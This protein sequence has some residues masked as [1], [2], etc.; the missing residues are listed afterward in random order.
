MPVTISWDDH[1]IHI[2]KTY[3]SLVG[4]TLYQLDTE[5]FRLDLRA[6][7]ADVYGIVNLKTHDHNTEQTIV[8]TTYARGI[9]ILSPYSIEFEDGQYTVMLVGSNN[10]IFD[11]QNGILAQN[12]VQVIPTNSAGLIKV[13]SGS[14]VTEQDKLDIADRVWDETKFGHDTTS[15]YGAMI[16]AIDVR[17]STF[18]WEDI[19]F[20]VDAVG[21]KREIVG[22]QEIFYKADNATEIMRFNLYDESN[23]PSS[24]NVYKRVRV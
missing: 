24:I 10:N 12:Q 2:P 18:D 19:V 23:N 20:M 6:L 4:G 3:L 7:E 14:G 11:V 8:G 9:T 16:Q 21:G 1:V 22:T 5:Q 17:T 13:T 15:S